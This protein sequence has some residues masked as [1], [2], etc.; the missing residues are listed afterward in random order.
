M[1]EQ[2]HAEQVAANFIKVVNKVCET[3]RRVG[4]D[5]KE[6]TIVGA[7]KSVDV[8][9]IKAAIAVGLT[10]IGENYVQE[11]LRKYESIGDAVRWHFIGH[12]QSNKA[13]YVVRFCKLIQSL[14]RLSLAEELSKR[15][16]QLGRTIDVLVQV[17]IGGEETKFGVPPSEAIELIRAVAKLEGIKVRGLMC[18]PPYKSDPEDVRPYFRKMMELFERIE[19]A[20]IYGVSMDYLSMGMSHDYE[21][22]IEE[23][24]NMVRIGT[25]IFGPRK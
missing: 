21:V 17:N 12:L 11:A 8:E 6:I 13:K 4:R 14:D 25:A 20:K 5:P 2:I 18:I 9:R 22:A 23:G 10:D 24:A 7:T 15:A 16:F 1:I 3:A 19:R